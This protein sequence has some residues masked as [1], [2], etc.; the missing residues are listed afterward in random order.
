MGVRQQ[1]KQDKKQCQLENQILNAE[2]HLEQ[3]IAV[4]PQ[5]QKQWLDIGLVKNGNLY[6]KGL[7]PLLLS[8]HVVNLDYRP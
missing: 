6:T 3:D 4:A 5:V 1:K 8:R 2:K 7:R